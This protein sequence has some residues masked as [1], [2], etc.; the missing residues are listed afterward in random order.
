M[1]KM[2]RALCLVATGE[3]S[4]RE[5][6]IPTPSPGEVL[7]RVEAAGLCGTDLELIADPGRF[8]NTDITKPL[9]IG[10]EFSGRVVRMPDSRHPWADG[11][12]VIPYAVRGCGRCYSCCHA[13]ENLCVARPPIKGVTDHGGAAEFVVVASEAVVPAGD[14]DPILAAGMADAGM[15]AWH[16][17]K[18][19]K[20]FLRPDGQLVVIG[21]GGVGHLVVQV[22]AKSG[23]SVIAV[24]IDPSRL[25]FARRLG[26]SHSMVVGEA[27]SQI[28][29]I[30]RA[31][32][33][34]AVIDLVGSSQTLKLAAS[35]VRPGGIV[36]VVGTADG[37]LPFG[38]GKVAREVTFVVMSGGTRQD[39]A[40][41][42]ESAR[43]D[44]L[45]F[46][47][48]VWPLA[49]AESALAALRQGRGTG[50]VV[51]HVAG[52]H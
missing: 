48:S 15:T 18:R 9:I 33:V 51:I 12:L 10:H 30:A 49:E 45:R 43:G 34:D 17:V 3:V 22:A 39:L 25:A 2:M 41:V 36:A 14:L 32:H 23:T 5:M 4:L 52:Q 26:A 28:A 7:L 13:E 19:T 8:G 38:F 50:R 40:D 44:D 6:E 46:S 11:Q 29:D 35:V 20:P 21:I 31:S 24:D 1:K 27:S 37:T 42:V 16:A 47:Y